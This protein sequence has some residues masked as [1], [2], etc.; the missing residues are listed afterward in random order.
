MFDGV[1]LDITRQKEVEEALRSTEK[2]LRDLAELSPQII[3]ESDVHGTVTFANEEAERLLGYRRE[4]IIGRLNL[5]TFFPPEEVERVRA[6]L[7]R[8]A[9]GEGVRGN[10]YT[11]RHRNGATF[12]VI[13]YTTVIVEEGRVTGFRGIVVDITQIKEAEEKLRESEAQYRDIFNR[14]I[15]GIFRSTPEGRYVRA[16]PALAKMLGYDS[17]EDLITSVTDIGTQLYVDPGERQVLREQ[18]MREGEVRGAEV[19]LKRK[20]GTV[21]WTVMNSRAVKDEEGRLLYLQGTV[22]DIT[23]RKQAEDALR[24]SELR[25]RTLIESSPLPVLMARQGIITYGNPAFCELARVASGGG[26]RGRTILDFVAPEKRDE[27][28]AYVNRRSRGESAPA[29][30]ESVGLRGDGT[31][32][33]YVVHVAT[34]DLADGPVT[35]A[36]VRDITE[37]KE[38]E[39]RIIESEQS[40]AATLAASPV[41]ITRV[42]D[43]RYEWVNNRQCELTGYERHELEGQNTRF[44][45]PDDEEYERAGRI[46]YTEGQVE[47]RWV[48]KDGA[49][50]NVLL[51]VAST[52]DGSYIA[53]SMDITDRKTLQAQ[54]F[55]SQ[56]MEAL[57]TLAGGIAHDFNNILSAI[58]GYA[59]LLHMKVERD[60]PLYGYVSQILTSAGKASQ[61]VQGLLAFSR[62]QEMEFKPVLINA[63]IMGIQ[64]LLS[65]LLTEDIELK[66]IYGEDPLVVLGDATQIDQVIINLVTNARD[67]MPKGGSIT[68]RTARFTMDSDFVRHHGFGVEGDYVVIQVAD[69]GIGMDDHVRSKIFEPFFTTKA[70]GKGTGLGLAL[71]YGIVDQHKGFIDVISTPGKGTSFFI[72]LPLSAWAAQGQK[73]TKREAPGGTERILVAEDNTDLRNLLSTILSNKGYKVVAAADGLEACRLYDEHPADMVLLDVIMPKMNGREVYE[74]LKKKYPSLRALFM[75]GYTDDIIGEKGMIDEGVELVM[76]PITPAALLTKVREVLDR[77]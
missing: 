4:E 24:E 48:R 62:K 40:L 59:S 77:S 34:V 75:S 60:D 36:F 64:K 73:E 21:I 13:A 44:L 5:I 58:M 32:F 14:A 68:I 29:T 27:V 47:T 20:D 53:T 9:L 56:K 46:L 43:R 26:L 74:T 30:Y 1:M 38:A 33:P 61:L 42:K 71:V 11:M 65:R 35:L 41:G 45:Y 76:K 15:E 22:E 67:A 69:T 63:T 54:L 70:V 39:R 55:Q 51:Q 25:F 8:I 37:A 10:E 19:R 7:G 2:R 16:N 72:Y 57:G 28:A 66:T 17:P 12:P 23:Q 50:R 52:Q 6:S 49:V 18:I 31:S 3:W